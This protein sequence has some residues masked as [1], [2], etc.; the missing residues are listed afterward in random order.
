MSE[1]GGFL[2]PSWFADV[3]MGV[4]G[5]KEPEPPTPDKIEEW[6]QQDMARL[7]EELAELEAEG[8]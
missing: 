3:L 1:D 6:R 2:L 4:P 8:E 5:A 7:R